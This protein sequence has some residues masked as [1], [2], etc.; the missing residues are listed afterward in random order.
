MIMG[1]G[2]I[3]TWYNHILSILVITNY[4][5]LHYITFMDSVHPTLSWD[6]YQVILQYINIF[7]QIIFTELTQRLHH[8]EKNFAIEDISRK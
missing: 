2:E 6:Y 1:Q 5:L 8:F 4:I 7:T 3:L